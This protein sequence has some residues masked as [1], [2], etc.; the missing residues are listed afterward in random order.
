MSLGFLFP[1]QGA[2]SP[3][4]GAD[5]F[6]GFPD[7]LA[8][9][10]AI[11]GYSVRELC[12][13]DGDRLRRT[14][15]AQ[16]A[17]FVVNALSYLRRREQGGA[18]GYLAG[19]S[20]GEYNALLAAGCI[21]FET[22]LR[23]VHRR[24]ELMSRCSGGAM[25]AVLGVERDRLM[26]LIQEAGIDD[27]DLANHNT[28]DQLV[29]AGPRT[30]CRA[31]ADVV[32]AGTGGRAVPLN[33][34]VAAHSRYME[35]AAREFAAA[36]REVT[37][38]EPTIPVIGNVSAAP[39]RDDTIADELL[40]HLTRPVMWWD[41]MC[42]LA[43][44][45]VVDIEEIGPGQVLTTMWRKSEADLPHPVLPSA[46]QP[47]AQAEPRRVPADAGSD[48]PG[49][50]SAEFRRDYRTRY[51]YLAGGMGHGI[52]GPELV[53][54]LAE[55]GLVGFLGTVGQPLAAVDE[56][57]TALA[58]AHGE[59]R[60]GLNLPAGL[61]EPERVRG[62]VEMG[63]R[64]GVR[65]AEV[66]GF[67]GLT[68]SVVR[69]RFTGAR[70]LPDGGFVAERQLLVKV[71][72]VERAEAFLRPAPAEV[73]AQLRADE[74]LTDEEAAAA[75]SLPVASDIC[76][77]GDSGWLAG[78]GCSATLLPALFM[79]RD[80]ASAR[81]GYRRPV[82][83]GASGGIGDASAVAAAFLI[84]ADFVLTGSV[85]QCTPQAR[86]S[87][88]VKD[89]LATLDVDDT[90]DA[91]AGELFELGGRTRV[92]RRGTLFPARA[93]RLQ[94]IY[95]D[96][97]SLDE[98]DQPTLRMLET[99]YFRR[100]LDDV[101]NEVRRDP[102]RQ[103]KVELRLAEQNPKVWMAL[104]LRWFFRHAT[105]AALSGAADES[106]NF[107]IPCGPAM[108]AFNRFVAGT[109]LAEWR[110]RDVDV[111]A[112]LLMVGAAELLESRMRQLVAA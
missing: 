86:T 94:R 80:A 58:A 6:D 33:V 48:R 92:V 76:V 74:V 3:G 31:V 2:Q 104:V 17:I 29:L 112:D 44:R 55:A 21:D 43:R 12:L 47:T 46:P 65:H 62:L 102:S 63:L 70:Q 54:R 34:S 30:A 45:G 73:I 26:D 15:N 40:H 93:A 35:P 83:V 60:W 16:P 91:P 89:L 39:L 50:G 97:A 109:P 101:W 99:K 82:R 67:P 59:P 85:N 36:L 81:Y 105:E 41:T 4:M 106:L 10:D 8:T 107:Q 66:A 23:L 25:T 108:G 9:A 98:I 61:E 100:S 13:S 18:P 51:A 5:L 1:G 37:F 71:I 7:L 95:R 68:P 84:G 49:L 72:R 27:V 96:H 52:S 90:G 77:E 64:H 69:W 53:G 11:L 110:S 87:P 38:A 32:A 75:A 14:E 88:E 28:P 24:G 22:G 57:L 111:I 19:H 56:D 78:G 20:L 79:T 42:L 103:R